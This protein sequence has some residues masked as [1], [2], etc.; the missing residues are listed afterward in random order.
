MM[1]TEEPQVVWQ[2]G[3]KGKEEGGDAP[4]RK[5][6]QLSAVDHQMCSVVWRVNLLNADH[7]EQTSIS[8]KTTRSFKAELL[9]GSLLYPLSDLWCPSGVRCSSLVCLIRETS[10]FSPVFTASG[11]TLDLSFLLKQFFFVNSICLEGDGQRF[12]HCRAL[13]R[14]NQPGWWCHYPRRGIQALCDITSSV[15]PVCFSTYFLNWLVAFLWSSPTISTHVQFLKNIGDVNFGWYRNFQPFASNLHGFPETRGTAT[16]VMPSL[17]H[18]PRRQRF[19]S[20][21][22]RRTEMWKSTVAM[23]SIVVT[24]TLIAW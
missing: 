15:L 22:R 20:E 8:M 16:L 11:K 21:P 7:L 9:T 19:S 13:M 23:V 5:T 12:Y 18:L 3:G 24:T 17:T 4:C 2:E 10:S 6:R 1:E 14:Q